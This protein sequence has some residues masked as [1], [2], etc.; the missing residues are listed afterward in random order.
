MQEQQHDD[1]EKRRR[2]DDPHPGG[3]P[4]QL[5][6]LAGPLEE[7]A[8]RHLEPAIGQRRL[9]HLLCLAHVPAEIAL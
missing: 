2:N 9:D 1:E 4:L 5:F 6:V 3:H 7:V 8:L